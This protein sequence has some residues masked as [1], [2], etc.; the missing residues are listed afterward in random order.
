MFVFDDFDVGWQQLIVARDFKCLIDRFSIGAAMKR[1]D[2]DVTFVL[3]YVFEIVPAVVE[4]IDCER[5]HIIC[6]N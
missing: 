4:R 5:I 6:V 1:V 3:R 2:F